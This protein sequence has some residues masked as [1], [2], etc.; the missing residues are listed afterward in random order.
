MPENRGGK[1]PGAGRKPNPPRPID[2][3]LDEAITPRDWHYLLRHLLELAFGFGPD[4]R[5][6]ASLLMRYRF[7]PTSAQPE[8]PDAGD[9]QPA[10]HPAD[11]PAATEDAS[12][13]AAPVQPVLGRE[14]E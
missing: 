4:S 13:S 1:R 7:G 11:D 6:A 12:P 8:P 5:Y 10:D 14:F 2:H 3:L 9:S